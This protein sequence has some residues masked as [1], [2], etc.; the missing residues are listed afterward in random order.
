MVSSRVIVL[1]A[2]LAALML[3]LCVTPGAARAADAK[4][5]TTKPNIILFMTDDM[6]VECIGA[7]GGT[8][9]PTPHLDKLAKGGMRFDRCYAQP[10]CTP[11]RVQ[12]MTGLYNVRNYVRF[13]YIPTD[14]TTFAHLFKKAG[15]ATGIVGKWQLGHDKELP[16]KMGFDE[17]C[18]WQ[19]TRRPPRFANPG[20]EYNGVEKDFNNGEY[21]PDLV[22][23]YALDFIARHKDKP[24]LLYYPMILT[25]DP[26]QPTPDSPDW[27]PKA[28]GERV[29]RHVKHF[30]EMVTY[31]DKLVG[32]VVA[33]LEKHG[34]REKTLV[35]FIGD[36]GT[37]KGA[38]STMN[39]REIPGGK[40]TPLARG[41]HVP[42]IISW[43]G[44][45]KSGGVC[46]DLIDSTDF[47]PTICEAAGVSIPDSMKPDGRSFLP[48][49][50]GEKGNP[51]EWIYCW[52]ARNGG[53]KAQ[54]EFAM[55]K[56]YKLYRDGEFYDLSKDIEEKN[57]LG[58]GAIEGDAAADHKKLAAVLEQ[59]KDARPASLAKGAGD[60]SANQQKK[61]KAK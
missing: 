26:Y 14:S 41:M 42:C 40:G 1:H 19:H 16:K 18:L 30:G 38:T 15:Y 53:A 35:I 34:L 44:A 47:L 32:R 46:D 13:G 12:L 23:D 57:P 7:H 31:C 39:G 61:N 10:L 37:G 17:S 54:H 60:E 45:A 22:N 59:F 28:V 2:P 56:Q 33:S 3:A 29:N 11:T 51:R 55:T 58:K 4:P 20:L 21:G 52:Y 9:Y 25:H 5:Q 8:S 27:D 43:P 36:N 24:F 6:G 49:I 48:Q 50:R